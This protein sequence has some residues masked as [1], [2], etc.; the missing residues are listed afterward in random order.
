VGYAGDSRM[1]RGL[2][3]DADDLRRSD[4]FDHRSA[5]GPRG[6]ASEC[7]DLPVDCDLVF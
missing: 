7:V 4:W 5:E 2:V 6:D 3:D 1:G